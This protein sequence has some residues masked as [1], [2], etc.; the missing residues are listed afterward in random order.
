MIRARTVAPSARASFP[1][2][3]T[4]MARVRLN[5]IVA[6]TS[7]AAFAVNRLEGRWARA[8]AFRSA[9]ICSTTAWPRCWDSAWTSGA[10]FVVKMA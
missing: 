10:G 2:A 4:P 1:P 9:M 7:Q 8:E 6:A 3:V 5:V